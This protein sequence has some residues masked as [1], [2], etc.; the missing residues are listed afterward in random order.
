MAYQSTITYHTDHAGYWTAQPVDSSTVLTDAGAANVGASLLT[1]SWSRSTPSG[2]REDL[3]TCTVAVAKQPGGNLWSTLIS[4]D[5]ATVEGYFDTWWLTQ[6]TY[7]ANQFMLVEY[8]WHDW[9]LTDDLLG[10]AD[11][12]TSRTVSG[13]GGAVH[14]IPDQ[15]AMTLTFRTASRKHWG[16]IYL[17]GTWFSGLDPA[18]GRWASSHVDNVAAAWHTML[19]SLHGASMDVVVVSRKYRGILQVNELQVDDVPDIQRRRRPKQAAYRKVYT[20]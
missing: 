11:R 20:S 10:P 9:V 4:A 18:Y 7:V 16:R 8:R 12:V 3:C 19:A 15:D 17:P 5:K 1:L 2:T 6:K 14:R 13:T